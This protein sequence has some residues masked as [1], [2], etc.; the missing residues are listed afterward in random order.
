MEENTLVIMCMQ[1]VFD[2]ANDPETINNVEKLI[3]AAKSKNDPI[4]FIQ[5][6]YESP[7]KDEDYPPTHTRLT[8]HVVKYDR[9]RRVDLYKRYAIETI[10]FRDSDASRRIIRT[11]RER[12]FSL[13]DVV[14]CGT[15]TDIVVLDSVLGLAE[16]LPES[17]ISVVMDACNTLY[18]KNCWDRF[19]P[20]NIRLI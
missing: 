19:K 7:I 15:N 12:G 20:L 18:D 3:L 11:C 6:P 5:L 14:A 16:K 10:Y 1:E 4:V 13:K 9:G 2:A 8:D 17:E